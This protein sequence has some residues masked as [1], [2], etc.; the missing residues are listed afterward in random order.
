MSKSLGTGIDPLVEIDKSGA[1]AVR[2]GMLAMSSTQDVRYSAEKIEQ[3]ERL[4]NKLF[5]AARFVIL[6]IGEGSPAAAPMST[7]VED[8]W[9]LSRLGRFE[10]EMEE[11]I[12]GYDF[13][14]VAR[15]LYD[16]VYGE[17]CD[18]YIELVKGRLGQAELDATLRFVLRETLQIAHPVMPFVTEELWR[19]VRADGEG[20]LAGVVRSSSAAVAVPDEVAEAALEHVIAAT[21]AI[22]NWRDQVGV[23]QGDQLAA[24]LEVDGWDEESGALLARIARL[25]LREGGDGGVASVTIPGGALVVL[26]GVD[27]SAHEERRERER[28]KL[29][30]EVERLRGKLANDGFIANAP[31]ELVAREREKLES[32]QAELDAL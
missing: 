14:H 27:L 6:G 11:R 10:R 5:N 31:A 19:Y 30:A 20:L 17:L 28:A 26:D 7:A 9:I 23:R 13:P 2:Y 12:G 1:D 15:A 25:G 18:W 32:L 3:G 4:A 21:Q 29:I 22:R 8:R 24:R 16:F